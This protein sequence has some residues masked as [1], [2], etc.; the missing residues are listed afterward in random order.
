MVRAN[1]CQS[2][3]SRVHLQNSEMSILT[4]IRLFVLWKS[5]LEKERVHCGIYC[6]TR[7]SSPKRKGSGMGHVSTN[8]KFNTFKSQE[9]RNQTSEK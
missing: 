2:G 5:F 7:F 8:D 6:I 9:N 4:N 3:G 1:R